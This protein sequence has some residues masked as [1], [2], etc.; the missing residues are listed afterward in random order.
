MLMEVVLPSR[1]P[2]RTAAAILSVA[3]LS[4]LLAACGD[5]A[6]L[7]EQASTGAN[8]PIP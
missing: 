5:T 8:P 6:K 4:L 2:M 7:P 3:C 1:C